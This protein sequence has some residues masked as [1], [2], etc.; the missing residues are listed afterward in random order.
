MDQGQAYILTKLDLILERQRDHGELLVRSLAAVEAAGETTTKTKPPQ[1]LMS[2]LRSIP[3]F[4][5]SLMAGGVIW[6]L[7]LSVK[8]FLDHGGQPLQLIELLL[9]FLL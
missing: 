7:G 8:S 9:K 6:T 1:R 3:P 4:A 5:Q 2:R